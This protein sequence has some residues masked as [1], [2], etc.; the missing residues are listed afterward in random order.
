MKKYLADELFIKIQ[1]VIFSFVWGLLVAVVTAVIIQPLPESY[2]GLVG[3]VLF[4]IG[5][6]SLEIRVM[7]E[8]AHD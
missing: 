8:R 3:V 5:Y 6:F 2:R 7:G 1:L 4:L